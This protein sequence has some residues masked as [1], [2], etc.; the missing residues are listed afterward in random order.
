MLVRLVFVCVCVFVCRILFLLSFLFFLLTILIASW[1]SSILHLFPSLSACLAC[2]WSFSAVAW[3]VGVLISFAAIFPLA[4]LDFAPFLP[5]HHALVSTFAFIA[6]QRFS[7][8]CF[9]IVILLHTCLFARCCVDVA[10]CLWWKQWNGILSSLMRRNELTV[11]LFVSEQQLWQCT[12]TSFVCIFHSYLS[13][14]FLL[15]IPW[16]F[17]S[18]SPLC[19]P[20]SLSPC[21]FAS[22][23]VSVLWFFLQSDRSISALSWVSFHSLVVALGSAWLFWRLVGVSC[24]ASLPMHL[25]RSWF[26]ATSTI[27]IM[28]NIVLHL[29]LQWRFLHSFG[30]LVN[31]FTFPSILALT[32]ITQV[33][34][35]VLVLTQE[36]EVSLL[37]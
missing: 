26:A 14:Y 31:V 7:P 4:L 27:L 37:Q 9:S 36:I 8:S 33:S 21:L 18:F 15:L 13:F 22:C 10:C 29:P 6:H 24:A 35:A 20:S 32:V 30:L 25:A 17:C 28:F 12:S 19:S 16:F 2:L 23:A 5:S 11:A 34:L 1:P 3:L